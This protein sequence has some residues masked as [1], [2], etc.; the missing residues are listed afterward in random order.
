LSQLVLPL[1]LADHAVFDSFLAVGNE[2]VVDYLRS[3][4]GS[5][6]AH[7]AWL[8]GASATGKSHLLQAA[9]ERFAD[10]AVYVPLQAL[11]TAG[12]G[13]L[14]GLG[15]RDLVCIDD[16]DS[17]AGDGAWEQ[18]LFILF[19]EVH[20]AGHQLVVSATSPP[21]ESGVLLPDLRS[22]LQRLPAFHLHVLDDAERVAALQLRARHRGL[23]LPDEA[24]RY[25]LTRS[26]RDMRS[27]YELLD[28][29][30]LEALRAQR[31]LTIPFVKSVLQ[32]MQ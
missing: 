11:E 26:A 30:D 29:L 4:N 5:T 23:D 2:P 15:S 9:C 10:R 6:T 12:P 31:R 22:R 3:L 25:L 21:R 13:L 8:W 1:Q 18:G 19:N 28:K 32:T 20:E 16:I 17:V 7:G 27:L 24:A 14:D